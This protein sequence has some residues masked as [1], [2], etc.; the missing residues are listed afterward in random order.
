MRRSTEKT[1]MMVVVAMIFVLCFVTIKHECT[2]K[3]RPCEIA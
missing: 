3:W 1:I 2:R